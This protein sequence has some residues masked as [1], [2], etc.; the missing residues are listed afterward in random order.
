MT[1]AIK[2]NWCWDWSNRKTHNMEG[3]IR[4][5]Y[6]HIVYGM[7]GHCLSIKKMIS[8]IG[9]MKTD[10]LFPNELAPF[11]GTSTRE[12]LLKKWFCNLWVDITH[13]PAIIDKNKSLKI[14]IKEKWNLLMRR[15]HTH[16]P[17]LQNIFWDRKWKGG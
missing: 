13:I 9:K 17:L 1:T 3:T 2:K 16:K 7:T 12:N 15:I 14:L 10:L 4:C 6:D 8:E 11:E 5:Y